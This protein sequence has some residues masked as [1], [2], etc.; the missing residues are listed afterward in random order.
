MLDPQYD[1]AT[2]V[3]PVELYEQ[4]ARGG[5]ALGAQRLI[6]SGVPALDK[7]QLQSKIDALNKAGRY[8]HSQGLR[9]SYHSHWWEFRSK[10]SDLKVREIDALYSE[11]DPEVVPFVLDAGHAFHGGAD[12]PAFIRKYHQRIDGFH[13]RDFKNNDYVLLG[14]GDFPLQ[15]VADAIR[16]VGW[17]GWVENEEERA[18]HSQTGLKVIVPAHKALVEAFA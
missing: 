1:Q 2:R 8:A 17:K 11:T 13:L 6:L 4:V 18:D 12:V 7:V 5:A 9:L 15:K 3:A 10:D 14:T 16:E